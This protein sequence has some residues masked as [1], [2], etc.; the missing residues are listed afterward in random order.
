[1]IWGALEVLNSPNTRSRISRKPFSKKDLKKTS[2]NVA[3]SSSSHNHRNLFKMIN[4]ES[5][6][7]FTYCFTFFIS[8]FAM[9]NWE[10]SYNFLASNFYENGEINPFRATDLFLYFLKKSD[11]LKFSGGIGRGKWHT[12]NQW[13]K[14]YKNFSL[15]CKKITI[16]AEN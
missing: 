12:M 13:P 4:T 15:F 14:N 5:T 3:P 8:D 11:N 2:M 10:I 1:M 9:S 7:I 6:I 16:L